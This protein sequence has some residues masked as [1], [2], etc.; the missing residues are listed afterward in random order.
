MASKSKEDRE[1]LLPTDDPKA[2]GT[3]RNADQKVGLGFKIYV[4]VFMTILW[5]GYTLCVRYT[6]S[7]T[8]P[9]QLYA[10]TTVVFLAEF[11]KFFIAAFFIFKDSH[12][13]VA[14]AK[15]LLDR[16]F[17]GRPTELLKMSVPSLAYAL[18]NNLDFVAL[19][20]LDA[21]VY[22]VTAQLKVV[23]T[24]L[25]MMAFLGRRFSLR[26]W[27]AI[28]LLFAGVAAVQYDAASSS[29]S[30]PS[31]VSGKENYALGLVAVLSTSLTA[32]FAGVYFEK[33]LKDGGSTPFWVRNLQMYSCGMISAGIGC[34]I[35]DNESISANGFF[36]GYNAKVF[37][38]V[39]CLSVGGVYISLVMKHLDNLYKSFAA[40]VSIICV[41]IF[42]IFLFENVVIGI[43]FL[44]GSMTVCAAICIYNSVNE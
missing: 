14:S 35:G 6:R 33:M 17:F 43:Y 39:A 16:E 20:N 25:F 9:D 38:I 41:V 28:I 40:A 12:F 13:N 27:A 7:T 42:S 11:V 1:L 19:S 26:R 44:F 4:I 3:R 31:T 22:Q 32:G 2:A 36:H 21:G 29:S 23:T 34:F 5:S 24:A 15:K 8:P 18:Q 37:A 10:S 30:K